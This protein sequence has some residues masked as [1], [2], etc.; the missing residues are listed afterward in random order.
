MLWAPVIAAAASLHAQ[1]YDI[2]IRNGRIVD[3]TGAPW[4]TADVAIRG[5]RIAAIGKLA[6]VPAKLVI[7]AAGLVVAPGFIDIHTH[8]RRG[9]ADVPTAENY[10]R[11][12]VTTLMEGNDGFS[13]VPL[14]PDL[15]KVAALRPGV[16]YGSFAGQGSI[17]SAV[18][19]T[20]NR[21]ATSGEIGKMRELTRQAMLDG[22]FG[23]STGLFYVPG[24]FTPTEE[25]V[26]LAKVAGAMGGMHIS[27]MRDDAAHVL[28][29]IR[30]TIRIGEEGGLPTQVTHH[31][32]IGAPNWGRSVLTLRMIDEARARGA[33]VSLDQY[34]YT[35]SST[36]TD[37][38]F[39]QWTFAGGAAQAAARIRN[40]ETRARIKAAI[41]QNIRE[42]RG[43]GNPKNVVM[44]HC[45]F[46]PALNGRSLADITE[47][48]HRAPDIANAAETLMDLELKG[49][50]QAVFHAMDEGDVE[51]IL[52]YR[53]TM[54]G[55]D[56]EIP[57]FGKN[58]P[59]PR[60]YGT[61]ARVL[62]RYVRERKVLTLEDAV[63][64]MS[65]LPANRLGLLD[66]GLLRPGMKADVAVFD[67]AVVADKA[68]FEQPH[69]YAIGVRD[70][71][72]NGRLVLRDS[73]MTGDRPGQVL[74]GPAYAPKPAQ[75]PGASW[76]YHPELLPES[77]RNAIHEY[78]TNLKTAALF[79]VKDGVVVEDWGE[80][81]R[82]FMCH[83]MRKSILSAL[84]GI[85]VASD[86]IDLT[87]TLADLG[88]DDNE[89]SLTDEEKRA[90][91]LDLLQAR[92]GVYHPA[93]AET[94]EMKAARPPRYSHPHGTFWYYN[95]WDFNAL[96]TIFERLTGARIFEDFQRRLSGP[97]GMEDF[98]PADAE[99]SRGKTSIHP[100][101]PF[102]LS[103]RDL[104]RVGYLY[105]QKGRWRGTMIVP[106][107]WVRRS[108]AAVSDAS[109]Q[110][111]A[112][113]AYGYM[114]WVRP[115]YFFAWGVGGHYVAVVPD[116][117]MVVV[118]RVNTDQD[119]NNVT[120]NQF[121][122]LM[123]LI[124]E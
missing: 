50:C 76:E 28:D 103:A 43:G 35:A 13:P 83:S 68:T 53:F 12:G 60:S 14:G 115:K 39:P 46:D 113:D 92:S 10:V 65:G 85:H 47:A 33:D 48:A 117:N 97:L 121:A 108:T 8:A 70:V 18:M 52:R 94:P 3:G 101:Y 88:I 90:T 119:G 123:D 120:A 30:E 109:R 91:V 124:L 78:L 62:G 42:D 4:Y 118:H 24:N 84:Y 122:K 25:V 16:N 37:A 27:H 112:G 26:E 81:K 86:E 15:E 111:L 59:H 69:Q 20:E 44:A 107:D 57:T 45:R 5:D 2:L 93:L 9:I 22:A 41:A 32:I 17:R 61:F 114:W 87:K 64:R 104:A 58:T 80:T 40:P 98:E 51:R 55:S 89:P 34:P 74:R 63:R 67:P 54:I 110:S 11:Q 96:G 99:Y 66:R 21:K 36:G 7:D 79:I 75:F 29:S 19:G 31:K 73:S 71:M 23:L 106:Q 95:N 1:P 77:R 72:V 82:K 116:R 105:A 6:D 102:R 49:G 100:A 56:G 38:L